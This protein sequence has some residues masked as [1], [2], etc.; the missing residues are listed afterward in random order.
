MSITI[1]S[2]YISADEV[3][4]FV[5]TISNPDAWKGYTDTILVDAATIMNRMHEMLNA[6][7]NLFGCDSAGN[8]VEIFETSGNNVTPPLGAYFLMPDRMELEQL[9]KDGE[10]ITFSPEDQEIASVKTI[11]ARIKNAI[12]TIGANMCES[13]YNEDSVDKIMDLKKQKTQHEARLAKLTPKQQ[14]EEEVVE[15]KIDEAKKINKELVKEYM[16]RLNQTLRLLLNIRDTLMAPPRMSA[17]PF[18]LAVLNAMKNDGS[19]SEEG[20]RIGQRLVQKVAK[21]F[22]ASSE[23]SNIVGKKVLDLYVHV[24]KTYMLPEWMINVE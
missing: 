16:V 12:V 22:N 19:I 3:K 18:T 10:K 21:L 23:Y 13:G 5:N 1:P 20:Y 9:K 14:P 7:F 2:P 24:N 11:I 4:E 17:N 15:P 8:L 6:F